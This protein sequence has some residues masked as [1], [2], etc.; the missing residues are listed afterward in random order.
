MTIINENGLYKV[1][2]RSDKPSAKPFMRWVTHEVIPSIRKH[3]AYMTPKTLENMIASPEFG[4]RLLTAL[5]NERDKTAALESKIK[6]DAPAVAFAHD[7]G[8]CPKDVTVEKFAKATFE[9]FGFGRNKLHA[10]LRENKFLTSKR[11]PFQKYIDA[12]WFRTFEELRNGHPIIVTTITGKGQRKL[13]E[14]LSA[15]FPAT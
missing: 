10:W 8:E 5:K 13:Y 9:R 7:V 3:G 4:I 11:I 2:L 1:I 14:A 15:A 12:G 6:E